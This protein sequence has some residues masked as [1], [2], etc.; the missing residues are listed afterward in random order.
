MNSLFGPVSLSSFSLS[1]E[2]LY[3]IVVCISACIAFTSSLTFSLQLF[4]FW[5][6]SPSLPWYFFGKS[7][8]KYL[9]PHQINTFFQVFPYLNRIRHFHF[10]QSIPALFF[11]SFL[12][13]IFFRLFSDSSLLL[14]FFSYSDPSASSFFIWF[15]SNLMYSHSFY[16]LAHL[17]IHQMMPLCKA[18]CSCW[19]ECEW[20]WLPWCK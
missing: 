3:E 12:D 20:N 7:I 18:L 11:F 14:G 17:Y 16:L 10:W 4:A 6:L 2:G 8:K 13:T 19:E 1:L 15:V 5:L 9:L